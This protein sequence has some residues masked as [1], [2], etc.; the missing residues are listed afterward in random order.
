MPPRI[1]KIITRIVHQ[2]TEKLVGP[3]NIVSVHGTTIDDIRIL[4]DLPE[5]YTHRITSLYG[6][7]TILN[8]K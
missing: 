1:I 8:I 2:Q 5:G 4:H 7:Y 3:A 6:R